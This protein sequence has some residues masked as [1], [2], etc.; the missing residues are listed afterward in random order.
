MKGSDL[1]GDATATYVVDKDLSAELKLSDKGAAKVSVTKSG[2]VGTFIL[3]LVRAIR[4]TGKCV[5]FTDGLKTVASADPSNLA[6]SLKVA[7]TLMHG[8]IGVKADVSN[9]LGGNPKI[10]ASAC[11]NLGDAQVRAFGHFLVI[12]SHCQT[13]CQTLTVYPYIHHP[14]TGWSGGVAGRRQGPRVLRPRSATRR[15]RYV[16]F[17]IHTWAIRVLTGKCFI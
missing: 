3:I 9:A 10:D 12:R 11:L 15:R 7:N 2:V 8:D 14:R 1:T 16:Y 13:N 6:K 17:Y 5:L 4:L